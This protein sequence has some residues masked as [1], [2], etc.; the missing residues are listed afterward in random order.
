MSRNYFAQNPIE[1]ADGSDLTE[2]LVYDDLTLNLL[3]PEKYRDMEDDIVSFPPQAARPA[4]QATA[5]IPLKNRFIKLLRS[6]DSVL[7][8][9]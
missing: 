9:K 3:V 8:S 5:R 7:K 1:T 2:Q 6:F 4:R